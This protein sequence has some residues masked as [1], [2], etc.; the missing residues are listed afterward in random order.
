MQ[1]IPSDHYP[2]TPYSV[3]LNS[4]T[5]SHVDCHYSTTT[6][7]SNNQYGFD[8]SGKEAYNAT[9][10][11]TNKQT[12]SN[13]QANSSN[14][15]YVQNPSVSANPSSSPNRSSSN[16]N[17]RIDIPLHELIGAAEA[18]EAD[19]LESLHVGGHSAQ[20]SPSPA[21]AAAAAALAAAA[22]A[23]TPEAVQKKA[24]ET[25]STASEQAAAGAVSNK[26]KNM[27]SS[28]CSTSSSINS[29]CWKAE[30]QHGCHR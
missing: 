21:A 12:T 28:T 22:A 23:S 9:T 10:L 4:P 11:E 2:P 8:S 24:E 13:N 17:N 20:V 29:S 1:S 3:D 26:P 19:L 16:N 30:S 6:G 27:A 5:S 7:T 25:A 14:M 15:G 18:V